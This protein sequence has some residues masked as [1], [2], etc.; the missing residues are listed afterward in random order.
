MNSVAE[1]LEMACKA[2]YISMTV[3]FVIILKTLTLLNDNYSFVFLKFK[4]GPMRKVLNA[5]K[6]KLLA[7]NFIPNVNLIT[8]LAPVDSLYAKANEPPLDLRRLKL[9]LHFIVK[10]KSTIDNPAFD[11]VFNPQYEH[12]YDKNKKCI[13]SIGF[14]IQKHIDDSNIP[15]DIIKPV[16]HLNPGNYLNLK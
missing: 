3:L 9:T 4:T 8:V 13:K 5:R 16:S 1:V 6:L 7:S 15:L 14:I 11:G 10:L 12:L 2:A